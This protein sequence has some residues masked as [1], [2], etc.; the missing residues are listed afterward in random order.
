[1]SKLKK[2]FLVLFIAL[3]GMVVMPPQEAKAKA[4]IVYDGALAWI[5]ITYDYGDCRP[6]MICYPEECVEIRFFGYPYERSIFIPRCCGKISHNDNVVA[7]NNSQVNFNIEFDKVLYA[8]VN[9]DAIVSIYEVASGKCVLN[10]SMVKDDRIVLKQIEESKYFVVLIET[11]DGI[12]EYQTF[13]I[14]NNQLFVGGEN[15]K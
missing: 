11:F 9:N 1:M 2:M 7:F 14:N 4:F 12:Y 3:I 6:P 8:T 13:F 15:E 5:I 10:C